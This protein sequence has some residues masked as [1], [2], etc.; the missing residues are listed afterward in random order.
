MKGKSEADY[1]A[2]N[3]ESARIILKAREKAPDLFGPG[4]CE[5]AQ[6][7]IERIPEKISLDTV[8]DVGVE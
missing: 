4:I 8:P 2:G 6:R 5:W 3:L 1:D 7:V